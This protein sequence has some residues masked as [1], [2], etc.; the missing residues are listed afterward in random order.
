MKED[1]LGM[2]DVGTRLEHMVD[3]YELWKTG[4]TILEASEARFSTPIGQAQ[5]SELRHAV[6]LLWFHIASDFNQYA[7]SGEISRLPKA[8]AIIGGR[9]TPL[10][11]D[12]D[13]T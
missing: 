1:E 6:Q 3:L 7:Y 10:K 13:I 12:T 4:L 2:T 8:I 11:D 9:G 5:L